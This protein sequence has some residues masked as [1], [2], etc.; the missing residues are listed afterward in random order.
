MKVT[1][2]LARLLIHVAPDLYARF[3]IMENEK[4]FIY[5][6]LTRALYGCILSAQ[7]FWKHLSTN[8]LSNG[9]VLIKYDPCVANKEIDGSQ[10]TIVWHV[11]DLKIS[12]K[13]GEVIE[14]EVKWQ[15]TIYGSLVG[16]RG[17]HDTYLGMDLTFT[18]IPY[19]QE[20]V[21][22]IPDDLGKSVS[23]T[24]ANHLFE[25]AKDAVQLIPEKAVI[26]H[27]T[28]AKVL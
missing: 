9:Y 12:N 28:V 26:F 1:G 14:N 17:Y 15:E 20:M 7:Q 10:I 4:D 2:D 5:L 6:R 19:L 8:L 21:D 3:K 27:H 24:A 18:M 22:E 11:D 16:S 25:V 13:K 23:T